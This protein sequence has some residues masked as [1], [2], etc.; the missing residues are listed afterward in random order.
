MLTRDRC[1]S[2]KNSEGDDSASSKWPHISRSASAPRKAIICY[3]AATYYG[4]IWRH[5]NLR[6][7]WQMVHVPTQ[8]QFLRAHGLQGGAPQQCLAGK[9]PSVAAERRL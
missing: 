2:M 6:H 3:S 4:V 7:D 9:G 5:D 8:T 1:Y